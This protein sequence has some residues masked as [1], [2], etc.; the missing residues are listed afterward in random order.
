M[1][2][3]FPFVQPGAHG[4]AATARPVRYR[5]G[6][7]VLTALLT[8]QIR[9]D[10]LRV[11][12]STYKATFQ[13]D[14]DNLVLKALQDPHHPVLGTLLLPNGEP[15]PSQFGLQGMVMAWI[16]PG[17]HWYGGLRV[18]TAMLTAAVLA[19]AVVAC[20]RAWGG[21]AATVLLLFLTTSWWL[22]AF[23]L[24]TYWQLWTML[25]PTLLPMLVWPKLGTGR[26][27]WLRGGALLAGLV[28][29]KCLCGYEYISTMLLA[30]AAGVAFHEFRGRFDLRF[31]RAVV[32]AGVAGLVGFLAAL[33][34]HIAQLV[35]MF[36][37]AG[38][39]WERLTARTFEPTDV[40]AVRDILRSWHEPVLGGLIAHS[41]NPFRLWLFQAIHYLVSPAVDVPTHPTLGLGPAR[42]LGFGSAQYGVPVWAFV[43]IWA[44]LTVQAFRGRQADAALQRRLA[45]AAGLGLAGAW[46]WLVLAYGHMVF[47]LH[48]DTIVFYLPFL[49]LVFAMIALRVQAVSL[50]AW[51]A[52]S[53]GGAELPELH[54]LPQVPEPRERELIGAGGGPR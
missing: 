41:D 9:F 46:S 6:W 24:S 17:D 16:S 20:W 31:L 49:P 23:G 25:L 11:L 47:H 48:I 33:G 15:Y 3:R 34:V 30:V 12:D 43:V 4:G 27:K 2:R 14:S 44:L 38:R 8:L 29:L 26:G 21:R 50:R 22:N 53:G 35:T 42:F 39:I 54:R 32:G 52:R 19:A 10:V 37:S 28:F 45:V 51:P 7:L 36:G 40:S 18:A 13:Q 5:I 1:L